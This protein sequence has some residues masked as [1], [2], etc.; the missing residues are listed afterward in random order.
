METRQNSEKKMEQVKDELLENFG[1][2]ANMLLATKNGDKCCAMIHGS[3]QDIAQS[4]FTIMHSDD[5]ECANELYNIV[6]SLVLNII[7]N[8]T[9]YASDLTSCVF[10]MIENIQ[11]KNTNKAICI[12]IDKDGKGN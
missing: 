1:K 2:R 8:E 4:I 9:P 5:V 10:N 3:S 12:K 6:K 7:R 11:E